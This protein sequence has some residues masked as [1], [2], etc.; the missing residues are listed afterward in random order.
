M[1][2]QIFINIS[3]KSNVFS[4]DKSISSK[5]EIKNELFQFIEERTQIHK[6]YFRITFAGKSYRWLDNNEI[7]FSN[8]STL[9]FDYNCS[10]KKIRIAKDKYI[11]LGTPLLEESKLLLSMEELIEDSLVSNDENIIHL[12]DTNIVSS[13]VIENWIVLSYYLKLKYQG[14]DNFYNI[15][16]IPK[17]L[18]NNYLEKI[19]GERTN[20]YLDTMSLDN[21]KELATFCDYMDIS[22]L[23]EIVCAFIANKYVK[24]K[25]VEEIKK[26]DLI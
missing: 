21:L 6:M 2:D 9:Q 4:F 10:L 22:Y 26:L 12:G 13:K 7:P 5:L 11:L 1:V 19:I 8:N 25:S 14:N 16:S 15:I 18:P 3:G 23:L 17:P 24:N 20:N